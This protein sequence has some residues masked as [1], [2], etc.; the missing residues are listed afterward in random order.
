MSMMKLLVLLG[1]GLATAKLGAQTA[2]PEPQGASNAGPKIAFQSPVQDFGRVS[3]GQELVHT[4]YFTNAGT[5][6]LTLSSVQPSCGC[7]TAGEWSREVAPG[8]T[9]KIPVKFSTANF[10]GPVV[11][12]VNVASNDKQQPV[13][14][15]Q[16]RAAIW[17]PIDATPTYAILNI[18]PDSTGTTATVWIT[19]NLD[20]PVG[21]WDARVSNPGLSVELKTNVN[22]KAYEAIVSTVPPLKPGNM[23]GMITFRTSATNS[24]ELRVN[25]WAN[26]QPPVSIIPQ[27]VN[28]PQAP[29][30]TPLT[31]IVTIINNTKTPMTLTNAAIA[32]PGATVEIKEVQPGRYFTARLTFPQGFE[33]VAGQPL[34]F[35]VESNKPEYAK[36]RVPIYQARR[37]VQVNQPKAPTAPSPTPAVTPPAA[38]S[39]PS[40]FPSAAPS[41]SA[42]PTP[43]LAPVGGVRHVLPR[44]T[45]VENPP[46]LPPV[47]AAPA[48]TTAPR[49]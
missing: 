46:R 30:A 48:P 40:G 37:P 49:E 42:Q 26:V 19:N 11:K 31:P 16:L 47:A 22:G 2:A 41:A 28:L 13:V 6:P 8:A 15:L 17:K 20:F 9:G 25:A 14:H 24:P 7:T 21:V 38:P 4:F 33:A 44:R 43:G 39:I 5:S 1:L 45:T 34:A 18:L 3:A 29:L 32:A 23:Q 12:T 27:N 10:N 35:T 36:I